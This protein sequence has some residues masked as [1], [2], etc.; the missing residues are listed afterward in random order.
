MILDSKENELGNSNQEVYP[1]A[2]KNTKVVLEPCHTL[3]YVPTVISS[4]LDAPKPPGCHL[5]QQISSK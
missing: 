4:V 5:L 2:S 1:F 3:N